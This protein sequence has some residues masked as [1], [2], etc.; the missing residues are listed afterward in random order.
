MS[1][2]PSVH[3][4]HGDGDGGVDDAETLAALAAL[5][6]LGV[7]GQDAATVDPELVMQYEATAG[8]VFRALTEGRPATPPPDLAER[9]QVAIAPRLAGRGAGPDH[10]LEPKTRRDERHE[11]G[12]AA[13]TMGPTTGRTRRS[14]SGGGPSV[15]GSSFGRSILAYSGWLA[16]AAVVLFS[17]LGGGDG[18]AQ[19]PVESAAIDPAAA[20]AALAEQDGAIV[21]P[22]SV[23]ELDGDVVWS[24]AANT[25]YM[26]IDGLPVNDPDESQYQLWIFRGQ[27]P[28]QEAHPIDGGVFDVARDGRVVIPIDAKLDVG[29]AGMFAVTVEAPGG[30]VVSDREEI[31]AVAARG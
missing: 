21:A 17:T 16:A 9:L 14:D 20:A 6:G 7:L 29:R 28:S 4:G 10:A 3:P 23:G 27:D 12:G 26:R 15:P 11:S 19:D 2:D 1:G 22:W 18:A 30:V 13:S 8:L 31:V 5:E 24:D 25:G